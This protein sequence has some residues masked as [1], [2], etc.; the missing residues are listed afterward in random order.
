[1]EDRHTSIRRGGRIQDADHSETGSE[2]VARSVLG[3]QRNEHR[4]DRRNEARGVRG[5]VDTTTARD[6]PVGSEGDTGN[7]RNPMGPE[8]GEGK[9]NRTTNASSIRPRTPGGGNDP[10]RERREANAGQE[11]VHPEN[12]LGACRIHERMSGVQ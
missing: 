11:T 8:P 5:T 4:E 10:A 7:R 2:M 6:G 1:M 12:R 3:N 9:L